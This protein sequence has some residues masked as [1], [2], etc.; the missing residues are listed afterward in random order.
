ME[1]Q[2]IDLNGSKLKGVKIS[3]NNTAILIIEAPKGFLGCG[4]FDI[5]VANKYND[6]AAIV[7][8]VK[9]L[10]EMLQKPIQKVSKAAQDLGIK[11]GSLGVE[12]LQKMVV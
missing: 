1:I 12:A 5:E 7:T 4:Y 3:T 8:G 2:Y 11:V 10:K 9:N 6:A